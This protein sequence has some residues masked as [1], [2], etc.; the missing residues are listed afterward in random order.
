MFKYCKEYTHNNPIIEEDNIFKFSLKH[1]FFIKSLDKTQGQS[2][3]LGNNH[4]SDHVFLE[5]DVLSFCVTAKS[6]SEILARFGYKNRQYF[7]DKM[8]NPLL[9]KG[10]IRQTNPDSPKV[11]HKNTTL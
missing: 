8:L 3:L 6:L 10:L 9:Q 11:L 4:V 7:R 1:N 2:V 5:K